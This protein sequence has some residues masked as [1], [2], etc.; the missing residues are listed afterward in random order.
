MTG[1]Q[2]YTF[3][4][5]LNA[6]ASIDPTLA[7]VLVN[8]GKAIL[9]EER[10]WMV[11]RKL[12]TSKA[13]TT[14]STWETAIDLSTITDLSAFYTSDDLPSFRLFDGGNRIE[15]YYLK[16][17]EQRLEWKD[18]SNTAVYDENGKN[19]YLNGAVPFSGTLY[20]PYQATTTDI[21]LSSESDVWTQFPA[22][23]TPILAYY[24][25]GIYKGAVDYDSINR[26]MLPENRETLNALKMAMETWD[27]NKQLTVV[28]NYDPTEYP[29]GY[30]RA[31]AINRY[32]Q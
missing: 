30:P 31:G 23:Y 5:G 20:L 16:P 4:T 21:D 8:N 3:M 1:A 19:L 29:G 32:D 28:Q 14:V 11:L 22:R 7:D 26:Q 15:R 25:I 17:W 27:S 6:E 18:T 12:D 9:E 13:I 2:L 10:P 24:A